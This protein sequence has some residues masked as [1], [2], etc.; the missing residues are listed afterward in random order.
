MSKVSKLPFFGEICEITFMIIPAVGKAG[1]DVIHTPHIGAM[2]TNTT[3]FIVN[4]QECDTICEIMETYFGYYICTN[5][6]LE[7]ILVFS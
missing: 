5:V 2:L 7:L 1:Q 6:L 3:F 4:R